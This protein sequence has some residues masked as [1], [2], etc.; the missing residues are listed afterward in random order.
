MTRLTWRTLSATGTL[1]VI[2]A[3]VAGQLAIAIAFQVVAAASVAAL[4]IGM[5]RHCPGKAGP[6]AG[7]AVGAAFF[8]LSY[9]LRL[10]IPSFGAQPS[11]EPT[12][13]DVIDMLGF[14]GCIIS[15]HRIGQVRDADKDP[16]TVIDALILTGGVAALIWV[17]V[18]IP[19]IQDD[20]LS[21][22]GRALGV[23]LGVLTLWLVFAAFR[24]IIGPAVKSTASALIAIAA[25]FGMASQAIASF[26]QGAEG[27]VVVTFGALALVFL[28]AAGLHPS[29]ARTIEP[30]RRG[31]SQ[32]TARRIASMS[33]AVLIAPLILL[34]R[35]S[36]DDGHLVFD[37]GLIVSWVVI[38]T[39]VMVRLVGLVRAREHVAS[40][41]RALSR[42][43]ASLVSAT[44][45][46]ETYRSALT[47]LAE[48][49]G[50][51]SQD[52][53]TSVV[54]NEDDI[55]HTVC[56]W[57]HGAEL[58]QG[59]HID[60]NLL[61]AFFAEDGAVQLNDTIA[62]DNPSAG[63]CSMAIAPLMS[64]GQFRGALLIATRH[65]LRS[66]VLDALTSLAS[67][68]SL[69][70]EAVGLSEDLF[71]R[72]SEQRF[73]ALV[74]NSPDII[75]VIDAEDVAAVASPAAERLLGTKQIPWTD[76]LRKVHAD[77]ADRVRA[78]VDNAQESNHTARH[79]EFRLVE[80]DGSVRW[81]EAAASNLLNEPNV[82]GIVLNASDI[83]DRKLAQSKNELSEARFRSLV[84]HSSDLTIVLNH[85]GLVTYVTAS[86]ESMLGYDTEALLGTDLSPIVHPQDR[87]AISELAALLVGGEATPKHV[88]LRVQHCDERWMTLDVTLTDLRH[89]PAVNGLVMNAH[90][91]TER[92]ALEHDLRHKVLHDDLTGIP[93]R[94]LF[95]DRVEHAIRSRHARPEGVSAVLFI[96][97]DDFKTVNDGL[98]HDVGDEFLKVIAFRLEQFVRSS[99]TAARLGGDEFGVLFEDLYT[100]DD[101][102]NASQRLL[103]VINQPF[104]FGRREIAV[105]A[106]IGIALIEDGVTSDVLLR[107]ADVAMYHAKHTGKSRIKL[108]DDAL[109]ETAFERLELK[110]DLAYA[111]ERNEL[112]LNY[113]PLISVTTGE[114]IGFEA[115]MRWTHP[116]RGFVSPATFIPLAEETGL[117]VPIGLW[118]LQEAIGQL[119]A[120]R[121]ELGA[122]VGMSVNV[123]P[124]QLQ[125]EGLVESV[126]GIIAAHG[127]EPSWVTLEL[128]ESAGLDDV[129]KRNRLIGLRNLGCE[130]AADDFG[131]GFATYAA[132][133]QLPFTNVKI[134]RSLITGLSSSD[135]KAHAQVRSIIQMGHALGFTITAEGIEESRQADALT[136]LGA[137]KMQGYLFGKPM[138]AGDAAE[139]IVRIVQPN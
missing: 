123:S 99:D 134:D 54:L 137:D 119:A 5:R 65:P 118:A 19:Y 81:L 113:Q 78:L 74:E 9:G 62:M 10:T 43:A 88:E 44:D 17:G 32:M 96:D 71:R 21:A 106:S 26:G 25:V 53:R 6:W 122:E 73:R 59:R 138:S 116:T 28:G 72:R 37:S 24:L 57:G 105:S 42:A 126:H 48:L 109:Y 127:V 61:E 8:F 121:Q 139:R 114:L 7:Y 110:S 80:P 131:T 125:E 90:D 14:L 20:D 130:I 101:V 91:I 34:G 67:D 103:A 55:W 98:G 12:P 47:A 56:S 46:D 29:M 4:I 132:L 13:A 51:D 60:G 97:V 22:A 41:E 68:V 94:V 89:D 102:L 104:E 86:I 49:A 115:L 11:G 111:L 77:D 133:Q 38:T 69:A 107:N 15:T 79:V 83:T 18:L 100:V 39:L 30:V 35:Q 1:A 120:W 23:A 112:Y 95:R 58:A 85:E 136:V 135:G 31:I 52:L 117:I 128:T 2:V 92:K 16:T 87:R 64:H 76:F 3:A 93:N 84:Q 40:T 75:L 45:R 129:T 66:V 50:A 108:F 70:I 36:G 82:A 63:R 33:L 27:R 124:R